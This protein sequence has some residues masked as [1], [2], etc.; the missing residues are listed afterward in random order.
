MALLS[1]SH[2][3]CSTRSLRPQTR[4]QQSRQPWRHSLGTRPLSGPHRQLQY[5]S[6]A[7]PQPA[8]L[9]NNNA[10]HGHSPHHCGIDVLD[11]PVLV[12][13]VAVVRVSDAGT[14]SPSVC[15]LFRLHTSAACTRTLLVPPS[16][17]AALAPAAP[18]CC[19]RVPLEDSGR[20]RTTGGCRS[21]E[22]DGELD[23]D[24]ELWHNHQPP[25]KWVTRHVKHRCRNTSRLDTST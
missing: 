6:R 18:C 19:C 25:R 21:A 24:G 11:G 5:S 13:V 23:C 22:G 9:P 8:L 1:S 2:G 15:C 16:D 4:P 17:A 12:T 7:T 3:A 20:A 10:L 14:A